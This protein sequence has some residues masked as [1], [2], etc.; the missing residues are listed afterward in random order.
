MISC[1][2]VLNYYNETISQRPRAFPSPLLNKL[3]LPF[4]SWTIWGFN[5]QRQQILVRSSYVFFHVHVT[6]AL[7]ITGLIKLP[8]ETTPQLPLEAYR[9]LWNSLPLPVFLL[10]LL[11]PALAFFTFFNGNIET[12]LHL[13]LGILL[14]VP[15][16]F[17]ETAISRHFCFILF[18]P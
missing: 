2:R 6:K 18:C 8:M 17:V 12:S 3:S 10:A 9:K 4:S 7:S 11:P 5:L 15:F 16:V 14:D 1:K 13:K